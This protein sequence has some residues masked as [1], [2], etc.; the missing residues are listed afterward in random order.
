MTAWPRPR[1][2]RNRFTGTVSTKATARLTRRLHQKSPSPS[3]AASAPG[4]T[5]MKALSTSSIVVI[6]TV[7]GARGSGPARRGGT[8]A[9]IT[10]RTVTAVAEEECEH[11][12]DRDRSD[13]P[14]AERGRD[15]HAEDL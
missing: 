15:D 8:P 3:P 5:T 12:R 1:A 14:P 13:V 6:E 7:S 11:D 10:G 2:I 9:R 4:T